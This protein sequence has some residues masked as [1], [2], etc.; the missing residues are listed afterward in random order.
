MGV[1]SPETP[2]SSPK[3]PGFLSQIPREVTQEASDV[4]DLMLTDNPCSPYLDHREI[5]DW[6]DAVLHVHHVIVV[7]STHDCRHAR[8]VSLHGEGMARSL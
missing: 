1:G 3:V 4:S 2:P 6:V 8:R 7:K 5:P